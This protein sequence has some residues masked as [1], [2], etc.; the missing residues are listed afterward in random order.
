MHIPTASTQELTILTFADALVPR[1]ESAQ[2]DREK[3]LYIPDFYSEY[4][5]I[6]GTA[7]SH[8]LITIGI[9]FMDNLM[10]GSF[11]EVPIAAAA[12]GNQVYAFFQFICMGLGSGAVVMSSQF[13]GRKEIGPMRTTAAMA[14]RVTAAICAVF[15]VLTVI[16][17]ALAVL[18][19][20]GQLS[21][22]LAFIPDSLVL[23]GAVT[24]ALLWSWLWLGAQVSRNA[25]KWP[26]WLHWLTKGLWEA[27]K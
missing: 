7:G 21:P 17:L 10:I 26:G 12:F 23:A 18:W 20:L 27:E 25:E 2:Y 8:P 1:A 9:N 22:E 13:W 16:W 5:Y 24:L 4:R 6:L 19:M 3:W 15:T 14:L 11:G